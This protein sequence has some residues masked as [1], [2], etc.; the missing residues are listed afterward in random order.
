M[1]I[2]FLFV[3]GLCA[4][5][6]PICS[7]EIQMQAMIPEQQNVHQLELQSGVKA[8]IQEYRAGSQKG[9]FRVIVRKP[10][11]EELHYSFDTKLDSLEKVEQFFSHCKEEI[12]NDSLTQEAFFDPC[13]FSSSDL[14]SLCTSCLQE[15]AVVAVGDFIWDEMRALIN[16]YFS[17]VVLNQSPASSHPHYA[18]QIG[19][20]ETLSKVALRVNYPNLRKPIFTYGD[21]KESWKSLLL[22]ELLQQRME[23]CARGIDEIWVHPHPRFFYPVSGYTFVTEEISENL[24]SFLLWQIET[25]RHDGFFEEEFYV[26]K[27]KL[28]NQ[29]H[30]LFF[31][32]SHPDA[33][34][35]ASYYAD[36]FLLSNRCLSCD[37]FLEAS[38][39]LVEEIR[40]EDL[41]PSLD[42]F[43]V[44]EH[45]QI[46]IIYP[47]P[48]HSDL[49]TTEKVEDLISKVASLSSFYR[50]SEISEDCVWTLEA[51]GEPFVGFEEQ[52]TEE[53]GSDLIRL[54]ETK[55]DAQFHL[56]NAATPFSAQHSFYQLPL[57]EKDK[58]VIH[59]LIS[60]LGHKNVVQLLFDRKE[61]E[62]KGKKIDHVH[63]LRFMGY[64][65]S[66]PELK[67]D[68]KLVKKS[69]FKWDAF[70]DG[71]SDRMKKELASGNIYPYVADFAKHIGSTV[72]HV[73]HHIDK[74]DFE[75]L[76]QS[77]L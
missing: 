64:I 75:G 65:L 51:K 24:L 43:L 32:A 1:M 9:S 73:K 19:H 66:T 28:V 55:E 7:Q 58:R 53:N 21:L 44:D 41:L 62:K 46:Q 26:T 71:F 27:R 50:N 47:M 16:R 33:T 3:V 42:S 22:Q 5:M 11:C 17:D 74:K 12:F 61:V 38:A 57:S 49:L 31:N 25:V 40:L 76:V 54:I 45:R 13:R 52:S 56:A 68:L 18:I 70:I 30:Y 6:Q 67:S 60:T 29:L 63:P 39:K 34:F 4:L 14:P 20:D 8:Y 15:V 37:H 69:S 77:L 35:L 2:P 72:E 59:S 36:Q 23:H 10:S 48:S